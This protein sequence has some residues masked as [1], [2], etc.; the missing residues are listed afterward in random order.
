MKTVL[1]I[2]TI[3]ENPYE[4]Y[5]YKSRIIDRFKVKKCSNLNI[6]EI[7]TVVKRVYIPANLNKDA[8]KLNLSRVL[9]KKS[10]RYDYLSLCGNRVFDIYLMSKFQLAMI[11]H[12]IVESLKYILMNNNKSI[13]YS[14]I[15]VDVDEKPLL[16]EIINALAK[17]SKNIIILTYN[18]SRAEKIREYTMKNYG[19]AIEIVYKE[20]IGDIDFIITSKDK[21]YIC[22]NVWYINN[23][24]ISK[25]RGIYVSD[26]L[27]RIPWNIEVKDMHPQL[28]GLLI[29]PDSKKTISEILESNEIRL[30]SILYNDEEV[31]LH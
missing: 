25:S 1:N 16:M 12:S 26:V 13:R 7:N 6:D 18:F 8:Y 31:K 4:K 23:F 19:V 2:S 24:F 11:S 29:K 21:E 27:Y 10:N 3:K 15:L 5:T 17:E 28:I 30:Q 22:K 14:N 20:D 9:N